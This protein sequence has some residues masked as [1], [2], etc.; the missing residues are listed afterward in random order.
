M[1]SLIFAA[2]ILVLIAWGI[3]FLH[4]EPSRDKH[5]LPGPRQFPYIGRIHDLPIKQNWLKLKEWGDTYGPIYTTSAFGTTLVVV[6]DEQ[7]AEDLLVKGAKLNSDRPAF[8]SLFDSKREYL[9]LMGRN[10]ETPSSQTQ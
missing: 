8:Q 10:R 2:G 5:R 1:L 3:V 6:T 4:R 7:I 9:P